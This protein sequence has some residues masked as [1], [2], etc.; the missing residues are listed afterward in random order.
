MYKNFIDMPVWEKSMEIAEKL[1][2]LTEN[3]PSKEDYGLTSQIRRAALSISANIAEGFGRFHTNDKIKFYYYARGSAFETQ[4]HLI[5]GM[6]VNY[7]KK[8]DIENIELLISELNS[9][10]NKIIVSLRNNNS[11]ESLC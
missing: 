4:N 11:E 9:S 6:R 7:F 2:F 3:L 1:F 5:Y 10:L 8:D